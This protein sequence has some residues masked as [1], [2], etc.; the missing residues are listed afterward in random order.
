MRDNPQKLPEPTAEDARVALLTDALEMIAGFRQCADSLMSDKDI[1]LEAL[2][3]YKEQKASDRQPEPASLTPHALRWGWHSFGDEGIGVYGTVVVSDRR[4][5]TMALRHY[6]SY[7]AAVVALAKE[8]RQRLAA[9]LNCSPQRIHF[10]NGG[11]SEAE[12]R[13]GQ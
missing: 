9:E 4:I 6:G 3:R 2:D 13:C 5:D 1:A 10:I 7:E 8:L 11:R 12:P